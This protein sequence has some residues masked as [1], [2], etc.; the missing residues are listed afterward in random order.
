MTYKEH[1]QIEQDRIQVLF[2]LFKQTGQ[3]ILPQDRKIYENIR[4]RIKGK[5][6][7]E[8]GCGIGL[9]SGI[10]AQSN[11]VLGTDI[12]PKNIVFAKSIYPWQ[13]FGIWDISKS[14]H[15]KTDVVVAIE[16]LE[17]VKDYREAMKNLQE[18]A[19]E[20][21]LSTPN[22]NNPDI[23]DNEALNPFH[24]KEFTPDEIIDM[25]EGGIEILHWE[26]FERLEKDTKVTPLVY[27]I[28]SFK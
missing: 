24:V 17:H 23:G 6:I 14:P 20:V 21:W 25:T 12:L 13:E 2:D 19:P 26:T 3:V 16:V 8:A 15:A 7:T 27:R 4:D 22:R 28:L 18:T 1:D 11:K 10:L 5:N 9:G